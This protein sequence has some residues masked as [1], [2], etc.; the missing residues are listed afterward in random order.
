MSTLEPIEGRAFLW[1][2]LELDDNALKKVRE[3][4]NI[5]HVSC[6]PEFEEDEIAPTSD[7][8]RADW[9]AAINLTKREADWKKQ[10]PAPKNLALIS[11]PKSVLSNACF[12]MV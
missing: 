11:Q 3:H 5:Q 6:Q 7:E 8:E 1:G 4:P 9:V 10:D 12:F 2:G